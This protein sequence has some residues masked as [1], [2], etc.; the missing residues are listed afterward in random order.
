[1]KIGEREGAMGYLK[2]P[3]LV[4]ILLCTFLEPASAQFVW[5]KPVPSQAGLGFNSVT[6]TGNQFVAVGWNSN[7]LLSSSLVSSI[8]YKSEDGVS[9]T[10]EGPNTFPALNS[11]TYGNGLYVAVGQ[12]IIITSSDGVNW[13]T[14]YL[15]T[16]VDFRSVQWTGIQFISVGSGPDTNPGEYLGNPVAFISND[17]INWTQQRIT[18]FEGM[19]Y[20]VTLDTWD[21]NQFVAVGAKFSDGLYYDSSFVA[22]SY[23]GKTWNTTIMQGGLLNSVIWTGNQIVAVGEWTLYQLP[24]PCCPESYFVLSSNN[25]NTWTHNQPAWGSEAFNS[26]VWTG[27]NF[28]AVGS[29]GAILVSPDLM[30]WTRVSKAGTNV[31]L[32][33]IALG[34]STLVAVGDSGTILTSSL[35]ETSTIPRKILAPSEDLTFCRNIIGYSLLQPSHTMVQLY[36]LKG[37]LTKVLCDRIMPAG[38]HSQAIPASIAR[39]CYI[40]FFSDGKTRI[41][42]NIVVAQ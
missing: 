10:D 14:R 12:R 33:S 18:T 35:S 25:G 4:G 3:V 29:N 15:D 1:V 19:A 36:N 24:P 23:D 20:S 9:W 6:W 11:V 30:Q 32:Y 39:G 21:K 8:I 27:Q 26:I 13:T 34:D 41:C 2:F 16:L 7:R 31:F 42:K 22:T 38:F 40:L 5:T 28:V 37:Q 17:G